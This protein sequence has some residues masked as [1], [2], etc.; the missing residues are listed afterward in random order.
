MQDTVK[1][2]SR[3]LLNDLLAKYGS[4]QFDEKQILE[5]GHEIEQQMNQFEISERVR[6]ARVDEALSKIVITA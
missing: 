3:E 6:T 2:N 5:M 1:L 4:N